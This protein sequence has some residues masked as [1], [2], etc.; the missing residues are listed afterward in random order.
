MPYQPRIVDSELTTSLAAFGGVVI[1]GPKACGKTATARQRA[2]SE[3]LLDIDSA[4]RAAA[5]VEPSLV[6]DGPTPRL[7]DEWQVEPAIWNHVRRRVDAA[8]E[9]GQFILTGSAVPADDETRH[10]GAGRIGRM[11]MRPMSLF[12]S[13][14]G[15][16]DI[17]LSRLLDG[18][19]AR[20]PDTGVTLESLTDRIC[21]GGW[22][23]FQRLSV[24]QGLISVSGYLDEIRRTDINRVDSTR[25]DPERVGRLLRSIARN[26]AT[27]AA[28]KKLAADTGGADGPLSRD[29]VY[30]YLNALERLMIVED[31][32]AW[33]P[34]LRSRSQARTSAKRHFVDPSLAVAA[35][36]ASPK[37]L[38]N[39]LNYLGF[40]F[41]SLVIRDLRIYGQAAHAQVFHYRDSDDL[42]V[43][44]V[45]EARDGRWAAFE[46][47]LG[48]EEPIEQA[49]TSLQKFAKRVDTKKIGEPACLGV[50]VA[51]GYGYVRNDGVAVIPIGA[52]RD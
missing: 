1:E 5:A 22:P 29:T 10:T 36:G 6:L 46:V 35:L 51:T 45:V 15:S 2:A 28:V 44:A 38:L 16:G 20:S 9:T 21:I 14:H 34:H 18:D 31:Q 30:D 42:E 27:S 11:R 39:D 49:A 8:S 3:V 52:L 7:I 13:G 43:D 4:A 40:L 25:R 37:R 41:E 32:P 26:I 17:W 19:A 50:I 47:K 33:A 24:E 12:E 23:A 48:G